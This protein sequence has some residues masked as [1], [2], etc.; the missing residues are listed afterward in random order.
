MAFGVER[1]GLELCEAGRCGQRYGGAADGEFPY[2]GNR[3]DHASNMGHHLPSPVF[4]DGGGHLLAD[5]QPAKL[6]LRAAGSPTSCF[7][8]NRLRS[9]S[10]SGRFHLISFCAKLENPCQ[11]SNTSLTAGDTSITGFAD[12]ECR[13]NDSFFRAGQRIS[14]DNQLII[15][16]DEYLFRVFHRSM[17]PA[18]PDL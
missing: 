13:E 10:I 4:V 7:R 6:K 9:L 5:L 1:T 18:F 3:R 14:A 17:P 8:S 12:R 2:Q 15:T 16:H 11:P